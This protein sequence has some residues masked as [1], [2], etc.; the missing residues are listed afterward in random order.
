MYWQGSWLA[1]AAGSPVAGPLHLGAA[2]GEARMATRERAK[3]IVRKSDPEDAAEE[4]MGQRKRPESG[5][6]RLQVDRQTKSS[7]AAYDD[8]EE[9]GLAIKKQFPIVQVAVYDAEEAVSKLIE[10]SKEPNGQAG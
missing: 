9:A 10:L 4:H 2:Q 3:I 5:R 7:Y 8:A 1:P 6:F